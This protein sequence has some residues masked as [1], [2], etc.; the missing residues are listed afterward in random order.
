MRLLFSDEGWL[1][2]RTAL[3]SPNKK[4][5]NI[6]FINSYQVRIQFDHYQL[7]TLKQ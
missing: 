3:F 6:L 1:V 5:S 4:C 7:K 2:V